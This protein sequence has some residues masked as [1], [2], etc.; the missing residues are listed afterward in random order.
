MLRIGDAAKRFEVSSR[1]LRYWEEE[2]ILQ[3]V[4]TESG[5]RYYDE[6]NETRI[7]QI[8]LLRNLKMP[9]ALVEKFFR[10]QDAREAAFILTGH[11][12]ALRREAAVSASLSMLVEE[13][14]RAV[15]G[16]RTLGEVFACIETQRPATGAGVWEA[17]QILFSERDTPMDRMHMSEVRMVRLPRMTVAAYRAVSETPEKDCSA[18]MNPFIL[19]NKLQ[20]RSGFRHF[21]FNSPSPAEG[22]PVY[23]YEIWVTV[24]EDFA[25]PR[26]FE[27]KA[28]EG[29][30]YGS[31]PAR[32]S[33]IG[34]KWGLLYH[35]VQSSGQY[36]MDESRQWLEECVDFAAFVS[37][38]AHDQQLDLLAPIKLKESV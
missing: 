26:P 8:Q 3:S 36:R 24:P 23:G 16:K 27:K 33:V 15:E 29:G 19:Q 34:E 17:L 11:L 2:G 37:D 22:N 14:I 32:L 21:G 25:V 20:E 30:L 5:Y 31:I 28:L 18:V 4:R 35:T 1:T 10:A 38:A 13:L 9:I 7:R 12:K 6:A